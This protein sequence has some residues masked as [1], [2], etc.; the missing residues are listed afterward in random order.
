MR[1]LISGSWVR[2]PRWA[3]ILFSINTIFLLLDIPNK[4]P[5]YTLS[6]KRNVITRSSITFVVPRRYPLLSTIT[7]VLPSYESDVYSYVEKSR[8]Q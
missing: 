5:S 3:D 8:A 1:L 4:P 6:D 7:S 2:A